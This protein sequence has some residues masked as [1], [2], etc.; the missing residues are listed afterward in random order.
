MVHVDAIYEIYERCMYYRID[1][2]EQCRS[3]SA[4]SS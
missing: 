4:L 3:I 1:W 2:Y